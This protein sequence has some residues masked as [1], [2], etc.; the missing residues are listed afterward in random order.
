VDELEIFIIKQMTKQRDA[1]KLQNDVADMRERIAKEYSSGNPWDIKYARGGLIDIDFIAQ[2][3]IL[4]HAPNLLGTRSGSAGDIFTM[5]KH[6]GCIDEKTADE[7]L[8]AKE[9]LEQLF[10]ML[11]LCSDNKFDSETAPEGLKKLLV[12]TVDEKDFEGLDKHLLQVEK[13]VYGY[14]KS[15]ITPIPKEK[16]DESS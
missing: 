2:Y 14:Y 5:L 11:R 3:M 16:L 4:K 13:T 6:A 15:L 12:E 7:L 8:A 10:N 1:D 9:F